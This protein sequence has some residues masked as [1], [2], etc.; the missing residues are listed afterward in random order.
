MEFIAV[1]EAVGSEN[2]GD[3]K[4]GPKV[5][6]CVKRSRARSAIRPDYVGF[7]PQGAG[8]SISENDQGEKLGISVI[9]SGLLKKR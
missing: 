4:S 1:A 6:L 5:C 2:W 9:I 8:C 3:V 7:Y